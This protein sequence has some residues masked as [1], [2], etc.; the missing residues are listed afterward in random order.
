MKYKNRRCSTGHGTGVVQA[1]PLGRQL[2][3]RTRLRGVGFGVVFVE[4][5][6]RMRDERGR[7]V[8]ANKRAARKKKAASIDIG[9]LWVDLLKRIWK[10]KA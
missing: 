1:A 7:T 8:A 3:R 10:P 4:G 6:R 2:Q 9:S 5:P